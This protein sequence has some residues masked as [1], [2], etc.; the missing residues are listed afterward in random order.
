M[1]NSDTNVLISK[2]GESD[3]SN[4]AALFGEQWPDSAAQIDYLTLFG[5]LKISSSSGSGVFTRAARRW[6]IDYE[7]RL[8]DGFSRSRL[9]DDLRFNEAIVEIYNSA[10]VWMAENY[11]H[12][13]P[14]GDVVPIE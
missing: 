13:L 11:P 4:P 12:Y 10:L 7:I 6:S 5:Y 1:K 9:C 14:H 2:L 8:G 3:A